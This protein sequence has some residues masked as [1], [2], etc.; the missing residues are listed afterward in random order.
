MCACLFATN[1]SNRGSKE[2]NA[3]VLEEEH[4]KLDIQRVSVFPF[5]Q[6]MEEKPVSHTVDMWKEMKAMF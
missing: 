2:D 4:G 3:T 1:L 6:L 5:K